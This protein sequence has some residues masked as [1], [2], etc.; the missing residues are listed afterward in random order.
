MAN[1]KTYK[2]AIRLMRA[3]RDS[4]KTGFYH[5]CLLTCRTAWGVP[6][7]NPDPNHAWTSMPQ[8]HRQSTPSKAPV[9]AVHYWM[10]P[11]TDGFGHV[12]I[13][14]EYKGMVWSTDL[15]IEDKV[16]LIR[17]S[18]INEH[19]CPPLVYKGWATYLNGKEL[20]CPRMPWLLPPN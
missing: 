16:G 8:I 13:Q 18:W 15:P 6:A 4:G 7:R 2:D 17:L 3:W 9:G 10:D 1:I 19:W 12:A 14:S 5:T 11:R 20:F